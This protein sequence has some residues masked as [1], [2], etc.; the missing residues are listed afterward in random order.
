MDAVPI[1]PP[2]FW[3]TKT[4]H[5]TSYK[6][7]THHALLTTALIQIDSVTEMQ[8]HC[9]DIGLDISPS[10]VA[11]ASGDTIEEV[12]PGGLGRVNIGIHAVFGAVCTENLN[13]GVVAMKSAQDG[14]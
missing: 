4:R 2:L 14:A 3:G 8:Y 6:Q 9:C 1:V 5:F 7:A 13:S 12:G 10:C 11:P